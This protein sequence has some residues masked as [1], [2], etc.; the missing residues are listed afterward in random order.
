MLK[1]GLL[2]RARTGGG[3]EK[4]KSDGIKTL[5]KKRVWNLVLP[6]TMEVPYV[7]D[8]YTYTSLVGIMKPTEIIK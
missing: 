2:D 3:S 4:K 7:Y 6:N 8:T 1:R 5:S